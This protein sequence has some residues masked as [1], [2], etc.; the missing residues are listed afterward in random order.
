MIGGGIL[1]LAAGRLDWT[2]GWVWFGMNTLTQ[3]LCAM[4]LLRRQPDLLAERSGIGEGTKGWDRFLAPGIVVFGSLALMITAG[5]DARF[6]TTPSLDTNWV[7]ACGVA[8][9]SQMFV[10]WAMMSNPFFATT[11]RIQS[12][13]GQMVIDGGPYRFVRHPGYAGSVLYTLT[14]PLVLGSAWAF[15]PAVLASILILVRTGLEDHTLCTELRG[16][17]EFAGTVRYRLIPGL[18]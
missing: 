18:W 4:L 5:L 3:A 10:L 16:Y 12:E 15:V 8:F 17:Q 1:F 13:R 14:S 2:Q 6:N 7:L 9:A 11:V